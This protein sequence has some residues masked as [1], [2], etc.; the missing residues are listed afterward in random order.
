MNIVLTGLMGTGKS[1]VGKRLASALG[2][3]FVDTD[4]LIEEQEGRAISEVFDCE[5]ELY[6]RSV[7]EQLIKS[8]TSSMHGVVLAT[9]GGV[10]ISSANRELLA[11]W[12]TVITLSAGIDEIIR[13]LDQTS[14]RPLIDDTDIRGS[15]EKVLGERRGLY[16]TAEFTVITDGKSID[17]V[18]VDILALVKA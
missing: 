1:S 9:G 15:L 3:D 4:K 7:E 5:G 8:I 14:T 11:K 16:A 6:F 13:R 18:V 10:V 17:E 12:G 2:L